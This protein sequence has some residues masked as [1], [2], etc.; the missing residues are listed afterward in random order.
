MAHY[1]THPEYQALGGALDLVTFDRYSFRA[2]REIDVA[3]FD[4]LKEMETIPEEVKRCAFEAIEF[5]YSTRAYVDGSAP[6]SFNA[7]GYSETVNVLSQ[8][9]I[10]ERIAEIITIYLVDLTDDNGVPLLF[11]GVVTDETLQ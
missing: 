10:S 11:R 6:K 2:D 1:L 8:G 5:L 9:D 3:T 4:R 7:D